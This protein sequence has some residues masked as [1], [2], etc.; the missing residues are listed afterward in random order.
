MGS[1]FIEIDATVEVNPADLEAEGWHHE[2]DCPASGKD[3]KP[4]GEDPACPCAIHRH[5]IMDDDALAW[6]HARTAGRR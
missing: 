4:R 2:D 3:P 1:R 6:C 5:S